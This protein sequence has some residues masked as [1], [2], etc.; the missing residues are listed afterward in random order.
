MVK[1]ATGSWMKLVA[2][3]FEFSKM[4]SRKL[5]LEVLPFNLIDGLNQTMRRLAI[6]AENKGLELVCETAPDLPTVVVGDGSRVFQ[7]V[8]H[9]VNFAIEMTTKG[10][11]VVSV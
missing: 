10:D 9:L 2:D 1:T 7:A 11:V 6:A 8:A 4:E 3:L 5:E